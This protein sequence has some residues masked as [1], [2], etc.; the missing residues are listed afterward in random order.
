M[1]NISFNHDCKEHPQLK[2]CPQ[3]EMR[4]DKFWDEVVNDAFMTS[5]FDQMGPQLMKD[6]ETLNLTRR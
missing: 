5:D 4:T 2:D 1:S 3:D 6:M